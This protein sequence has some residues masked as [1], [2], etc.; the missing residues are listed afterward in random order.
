MWSC[1]MLSYI[2]ED[3]DKDRK[4]DE[5]VVMLQLPYTLENYKC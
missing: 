1:F 2:D 3:E 4:S 5:I